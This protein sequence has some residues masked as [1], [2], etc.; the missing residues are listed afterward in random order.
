IF[1]RDAYPH[2]MAKLD[3]L[4]G[5][6]L[7]LAVFSVTLGASSFILWFLLGALVNSDAFLPYA[8]MFGSVVFVIYFLWNNF[9]TSRE[10]VSRYI[11][12]NMQLL[13]SLALDHWFAHTN[14]TYTGKEQLVADETLMAYRDKIRD[15]LR[16]AR[17]RMRREYQLGY[18]HE[19]SDSFSSPSSSSLRHFG[20][21]GIKRKK[22]KLATYVYEKVAAPFE[23]AFKMDENCRATGL[24]TIPNLPEGARFATCSEVERHSERIEDM[25]TGWDAVMLKDGVKYGPRYGYGYT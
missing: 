2:F 12:D 4:G 15:E 18:V 16:E 25:L 23:N 1:L 21:A 7:T 14:I 6:F 10:S 8:A 13:L 5:A 11:E 17:M 22:E 20:S 9:V 3:Y 24:N 19:E